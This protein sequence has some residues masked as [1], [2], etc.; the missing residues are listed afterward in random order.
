MSSVLLYQKYLYEIS[1]NLSVP[2]WICDGGS[3]D[4]TNGWDESDIHADA[5]CPICFTD[6]VECGADSGVCVESGEYIFEVLLLCN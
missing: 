2:G 5:P 4:C 3:P 6:Y 1:A